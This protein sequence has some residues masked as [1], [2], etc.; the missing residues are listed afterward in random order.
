MCG[1][2]RR[3]VTVWNTDIAFL[4]EISLM[5]WALFSG[6]LAM[7]AYLWPL[8]RPVPTHYRFFHLYSF[9]FLVIGMVMWRGSHEGIRSR[10]INIF[11]F[12]G[13]LSLVLALMYYFSLDVQAAKKPTESS[14]LDAKDILLG[15]KVRNQAPKQESP[16]FS[17]QRHE[18]ALWIQKTPHLIQTFLL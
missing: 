8:R 4:D 2:I 9:L 15:K 11:I 14:S 3:G 5:L 10:E 13:M 1:F 18:L 16:F 6:R 7:V 17:T 12:S